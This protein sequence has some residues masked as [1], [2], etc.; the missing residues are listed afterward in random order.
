MK[1]LSGNASNWIE[2][3]GGDA[4]ETLKKKK[5]ESKKVEIINELKQLK[6][7]GECLEKKYTQKTEKDLGDAL[8]NLDNVIRS[9]KYLN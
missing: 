6:K 4:N 3:D 5:R 8:S 9:L 2:N 7:V 1:N